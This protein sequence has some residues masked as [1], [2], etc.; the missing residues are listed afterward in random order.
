VD[1]NHQARRDALVSDVSFA[2]AGTALAVSVYVLLRGRS[3][4]SALLPVHRESH[5]A[6]EFQLGASA[7][8]AN[9][10]VAGAW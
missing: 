4:N 9:V 5:P 10:G 2:V 1:L 7:G 3:T 8:A 6:V